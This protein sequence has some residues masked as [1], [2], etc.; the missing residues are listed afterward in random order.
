MDR[1]LTLAGRIALRTPDGGVE[2]RRVLLP[3]APARM[4]AE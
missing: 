2:L 1:E 3:A 4:A